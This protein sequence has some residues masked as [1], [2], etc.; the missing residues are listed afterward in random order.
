[1]KRKVKEMVCERCGFEI[2]TVN[3]PTAGNREVVINQENTAMNAVDP[4]KSTYSVTCPQCG[5]EMPTV[6][7]D[8]WVAS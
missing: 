3:Q 5:F 7:M 8:S 6:E 4:K 2:I 1:M